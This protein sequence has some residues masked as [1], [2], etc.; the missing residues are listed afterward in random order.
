MVTETTGTGGF[1][2]AFHSENATLATAIGAVLNE[3][4]AHH[5]PI[6]QVQFNTTY[7]A[8]NSKYAVI[9]Y[10]KRH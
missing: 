2:K 10:V 1:F 3:L 8:G 7:D 9:A 4:G 5:V 6:I